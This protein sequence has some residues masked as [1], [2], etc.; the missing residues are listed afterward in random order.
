MAPAYYVIEVYAAF[1]LCD[2][3]LLNSFVMFYNVSVFLNY[4]LRWKAVLKPENSVC[5]FVCVCVTK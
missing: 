4:K 1:S 3:L 5:V 2:R